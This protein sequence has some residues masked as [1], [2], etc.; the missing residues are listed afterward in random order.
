MRY[1]FIL[2]LFLTP[3]VGVASENLIENLRGGGNTIITDGVVQQQK[4]DTREEN[5]WKLIIYFNNANHGVISG[6]SNTS[7]L[8]R[9]LYI[10]NQT[11]FLSRTFT[12]PDDID[13]KYFRFGLN[14]MDMDT[15][16]M[17][18]I[19]DVKPNTTYTIQWR[20][21]NANQG[22]VN[23][24][25]MRVVQC[26][27]GYALALGDENC[28]RECENQSVD[29]GYILPNIIRVYEPEMCTYDLSNL[30]CDDGYV[31][32]ENACE[33]MCTAGIR[34]LHIGDKVNGLY[35]RKT[36]HPAL[37]VLYNGQVCY[38]HFAPGKGNG[39]NVEL[40]GKNYHLID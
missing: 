7:Y 27:D 22:I 24:T 36:M 37:S 20:V 3:Y 28:S 40:N 16:V 11:G 9:F 2:F 6:S 15:S 29:G 19:K 33:Q 26:G 14:G 18:D 4:A 17:F 35:A 1:I 5:Q 34:Y 13:I 30:I 23:W 31:R 21:L 38:G 10:N 8:S 25:D 32:I 39:L 12:T